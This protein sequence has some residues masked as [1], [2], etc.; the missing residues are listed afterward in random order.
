V[1]IAVITELRETHHE[2]AGHT[3][4]AINT[5]RTRKMAHTVRRMA[6]AHHDIAQVTQI[7]QTAARTHSTFPYT[8]TGKGLHKIAESKEG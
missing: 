7:A 3:V 6:R 4:G 8:D 1:R 5:V 2:S